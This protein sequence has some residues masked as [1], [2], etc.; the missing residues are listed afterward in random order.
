M[1]WV[2]QGSRHTLPA[3]LRALAMAACISA[4]ATAQAE[5]PAAKPVA[6][7]VEPNAQPA[8]Y[9][10]A[11]PARTNLN[12]SNVVLACESAG[13]RDILQLQLYLTDDGPLLP[14]G[15]STADLK[16]AP[17]AEIVIDGRVFPA[18]LLFSDDHAVL[19]DQQVDGF[20]ALSDGVV[21][22]MAKG[23]TMTLRLDLVAE[24]PGVADPFDG[25]AA[26][27]LQAG[28]GSAA[29]QA[30]RHCA[31]PATDRTVGLHH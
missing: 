2:R 16:D 4:A 20:A 10:V 17:G 11:E 19:A 31:A 15:A 6:W 5:T 1:E 9:A 3:I 7:K 23:R 29:I 25:E 14:Q 22:A 21:D 30:V 18:S 28:G 12:I 13:D 24:R 26:I 27:D 8:R